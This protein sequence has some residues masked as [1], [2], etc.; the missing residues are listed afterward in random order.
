[1]RLSI[2]P[3]FLNVQQPRP[4]PLP[5]RD[6]PAPHPPVDD[7]MPGSP[8]PTPERPPVEPP[9]IPQPPGPTL[10]DTEPHPPPVQAK[11][12]KGRLTMSAIPGF[13]SLSSAISS[14]KTTDA[15][16]AIH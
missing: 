16:G 8:P 13:A 2:D 11:A 6:P 5:E 12:M 1:M 15:I 7:P 3:A 14:S 10:P 4:Q 9:S